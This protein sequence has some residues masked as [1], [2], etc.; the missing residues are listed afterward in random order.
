[1]QPSNPRKLQA[2]TDPAIVNAWITEV[3]AQRRIHELHL[4]QLTTE[5]RQITR[6]Q[7]ADIVAQV[8]DVSTL[9]SNAGQRERARVYQDLGLPTL[10]FGTI[11]A[12]ADLQKILEKQPGQ[13]DS[14]L[15]LAGLAART[16]ARVLNHAGRQIPP[17][18]ETLAAANNHILGETFHSMAALRYGEHVAKIS[19]APLSPNVRALTG[20][21]SRRR[22]ANR[23]CATS[24]SASSRTTTPSTNCAPSC[25]PTSTRCPSRT[26]PCGGR[27][28]CRRTRSS[29]RSTC[30]PR[31]PTATPAAASPTTSCRSTR[32]TPC[33]PTARSAPSCARAAGPTRRLFAHVAKTCGAATV[34][35]VDRIDRSDVAEAFCIDDMVHSSTDRWSQAVDGPE[36]PDL[37]I[38]AIGHQTGT[39]TD[40]VEA[41]APGGRLFYFGVPDDAHYV[42]P[43]QTLFRKGLTIATGP[44][45]DRRNALRAA[46]EYLRKFPELHENFVTHTFS[47]HDAQAAFELA[48][49][50]ARGRLKVQLLVPDPSKAGPIRYRLLR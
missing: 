7:I 24:T 13:S 29:Q 14:Q 45:G 21:R 30:W 2:G 38:E 22:P 34:I 3:T 31:T 49:V 9:L 42:I 27:R 48:P 19:A 28:T 4:S 37:I 43:M 50:P 18:V 40:A 20:T 23:R 25:A 32:G 10:P 41:L 36:R 35:G 6:Q 5:S 16:A 47:M 8:P 33:R 44:I 1:M 17:S 46:D 15:Q 11:A 26:P 39:L 12:Y